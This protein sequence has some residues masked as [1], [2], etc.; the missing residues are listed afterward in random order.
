MTQLKRLKS[1]LLI[2]GVRE[3]ER[4]QKEFLTH[5]WEESDGF[6]WGKISHSLVTDLLNISVIG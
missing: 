2:C 1:T 5:L 4:I 6:I 3:E